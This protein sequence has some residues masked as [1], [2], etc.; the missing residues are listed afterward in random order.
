MGAAK[1][2]IKTQDRSVIL[3][4]M[5]GV[6][7]AAVIIA[8][9][10]KAN[11]PQLITNPTQYE[12][13]YGIANPANGASQYAVST[14]L[15]ES[16]KIWVNRVVHKDAR[17]SAALVRSSVEPLPLGIPNKDY[18]PDRI[19]RPIN[20]LTQEQFDA[21]E[22][23][24][25]STDRVYVEL[26]TT[27][28]AHDVN[29]VKSVRL[30][31]IDTLKVG[32]KLYFG[33]DPKNNS[34]LHE[35]MDLKAVEATF[36]KL[37]LD[38]TVTVNEGDILK[39]V[40]SR[41]E[42]YTTEPKL[43]VATEADKDYLHFVDGSSISVGDILVIDELTLEVLKV[44]DKTGGTEAA[45]VVTVKGN[46]GKVVNS[47]TVAK[48]KVIEYKE[49]QGSPAVAR[50]MSG[51]NEILVNKTD[52]IGNGDTIAIFTGSNLSVASVTVAKKDTYA[53][54]HYYAVLDKKL[55]V[56]ADTKIHNMIHSEFED[57]DAFL[58]TFES[59]SKLGD[60]TSIAIAPSTSYTEEDVTD[61]FSLPFNL[62]VYYKGVKVETF[63]NVAM[64][65]Q[66]D[67]FKNQM[68]I[69]TRING[70]SD[71]IQVKVNPNNVDANGKPKNPA[72]TNYSIWRQLPED[73]FYP[74]KDAADSTDVTILEDLLVNDLNIRVTD[75]TKI[76]LG[77][78]IKFKGYDAEYKVV[79]KSS[80][81]FGGTTYYDILLDRGIV[82]A[83]DNVVNKIPAGTQVTRFDAT[84]NDISNGIYNG[85]KNYEVK[86]IDNVYYNYPLNV[87]F[88]ISGTKGILLDS[89][90]NLL[91]GGFNGSPVT[92]GDLVNGLK[93]FYNKD[94]YPVNIVMDC[95]FTYPAYAQALNALAEARNTCHAYISID[96]NAEKMSDYTNAIVNY[97]NSLMLNSE[98][99]SV[100]SGWIK[101]LDENNNVEVYTDPASAAAASQAFTTRNY[102]IFYPSAGW[103]RGRVKGLGVLRAFTAGDM[104]LL[105][106]NRINPIRYK[107]G[108]GMVIWGNETTYRKP[109]PLQMRSVAWLLIMIKYGLESSLDFQLFE[110]NNE[111]TYQALETAIRTFMRDEVKAKGGVYEFQVEVSKIITDSDKEQRRIPV[112]LGIKPTSDAKFIPVTIA[113]FSASQK[114]DVS[115]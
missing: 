13:K 78:R 82:I 113:V 64:T 66:V 87:L 102:Q 90:A 1:Y 11:V 112:F 37:T 68:F 55:S 53:E 100:F 54:T 22:F 62:I 3:A 69:E 61:D 17:F 72:Y 57:R 51:T 41:V 77:D 29:A 7:A 52:Y 95:G 105:V 65:Q 34:V 20:G 8:D 19:V 46:V 107:E 92:V 93:P 18:Q 70:V 6:Y 60:Y 43:K 14:F 108:S 23:P 109:S 39:M 25:Y 71:Y 24:L 84:V 114:I 40:A 80:F 27:K 38:R 12:R 30:N 28:L 76:S 33:D 9:K 32:N 4:A 45:W 97:Y 94:R 5:D 111:R 103:T 49:Y 48:K 104:D 21:Y 85:V 81:T 74:V 63:E 99:S 67:S 47:N 10:G 44:E 98:F 83:S 88:T 96:A 56:S 59:Q 31:R 115:L 91:I 101:T 42:A 79:N 26:K 110:L 89:G 2:E 73:L 58:V 15:S 75:N 86:K 50:A 35:V 36:E 16:N 106:D